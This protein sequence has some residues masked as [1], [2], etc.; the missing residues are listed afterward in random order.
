MSTKV[1][2]G[3][4]AYSFTDQALGISI[5]KGEIAELSAK[6]MTSKKIVVAL[7]GGHLRIVQDG[8]TVKKYND[9][10][11]AAL[12]D[13]LLKL[14]ASGKKVSKVAKDFTLEEAKLIA[15]KHEIQVEDS[16]TVETIFEAIAED[17]KSE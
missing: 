12:D 3:S 11:V 1:T 16:D 8:E 4:K 17:T 6:Q 14:L 9:A 13:K 2:V 5:V 15:A 10:D 7:N